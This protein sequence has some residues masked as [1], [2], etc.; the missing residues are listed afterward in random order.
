MTLA[1]RVLIGL[2]AGFLFGLAV[3][4]NASPAA[5]LAVSI[6]TP[7]GTIFVNLIR[8]T[9]IPLVVSLLVATVGSSAASKGLG[10]IGL[11]A[12]LISVGLLT[13]AALGSG[14]IAERVLVNV[15]IDQSAAQALA[16][17]TGTDA[18]SGAPSLTAWFVDLVPQNVIK[19]A[20]DGAMLP[21]I[22]FSV[23]FGLALAQVDEHKRNPVL[24]LVE[25]I[26]DTMQRLVV[27][28]MVLA[29]IGVFALA[30]PLASRL[31]WTAAGA[32]IAYV[33]LVVALTIAAAAVLLYP[34]GILAGPMSASAF[35]SFCAPAQAIAFASRSSLAALPAM[36]QS[37]ERAGLPASSTTLVLPMAAA[38]YHVGAAVAQTVGV[39]F[40][41]HLYGVSLTPL[42]FAS[43]V[44][45][46]VVATFAV[47]GI[48]GGSIIAMVP[49]MAA[50][51]LPLDGIGILLAVDAI[52]DMFRTTANVTGTMV[53]TAILPES[54]A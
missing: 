10:R 42:Q 23:M 12:L 26:A 36:V 22:L 47:P 6:L 30:V 8:M 33:G 54:R 35:F 27:K 13:A 41:A 51:N 17:P 50:A 16:G 18:A 25:G 43:V 1:I 34:L 31:G 40:L 19:A 3:S 7:I 45:S 52:P 48:P 46:V 2:V 44:L 37:A 29:P 53:L 32:V 15:T 4:S 5:A 49:A 24:R 38:V 20:A 9:V 11:R 14:L 21:L 28:V 39:V